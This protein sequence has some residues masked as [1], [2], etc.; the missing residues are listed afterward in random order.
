MLR[1]FNPFVPIAPFFYPL[2]ISEKR[3]GAL[4]TNR[5][6]SFSLVP[7]ILKTYL[8]NLTFFSQVMYFSFTT[9]TWTIVLEFSSKELQRCI[10]NITPSDKTNILYR[11]DSRISQLFD[12][13]LS[14]Y[15]K[16]LDIFNATNWYIFDTKRFDVPVTNLWKFSNFWKSLYYLH[17]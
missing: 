13:C 7:R 1:F 3:K 4:R 15:A 10:C 5:L 6:I 14:N 17:Q 11:N 8:Q 16:N 12:D 9:K 2:K